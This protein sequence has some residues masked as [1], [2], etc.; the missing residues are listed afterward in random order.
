MKKLGLGIG[1]I[2]VIAVAIWAYGVNY[3]TRQ[4]FDRL[5]DLRGELAAEREAVQV[6]RVEW[7]WLNAPDRLHR[8]AAQHNDK[9]QLTRMEAERF[10]FADTVPFPPPVP[11]EERMLAELANISNATQAE[12]EAFKPLGEVVE[13]PP[14]PLPVPLPV[15]RP[16]A[17][18]VGWGRP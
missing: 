10:S 4:A 17:T 18:N 3:R 7:A 2:A 5:D 6:L 16:R 8:L 12:L 1:L 13:V 9:L 15:A 14:A 11:L